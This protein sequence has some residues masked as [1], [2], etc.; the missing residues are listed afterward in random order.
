MAEMRTLCGRNT[1]D[2][3]ASA[4]AG[5]LYNCNASATK[6]HCRRTPLTRTTRDRVAKKASS[7]EN[8]KDESLASLLLIDDVGESSGMSLLGAKVSMT[9]GSKC[10]TPREYETKRSGDGAKSEVMS[11]G[12][13][14]LWRRSESVAIS[15]ECMGGIQRDGAGDQRDI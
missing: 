13:V 6:Q 15:I 7:G 5:K 8:V 3:K 2:R 9:F 1:A 12:G 10:A 14:N 11:E 4:I